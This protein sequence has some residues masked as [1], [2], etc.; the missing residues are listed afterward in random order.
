LQNFDSSEMCFGPLYECDAHH[1][2]AESYGRILHDSKV[3]H[4]VAIF[5]SLLQVDTRAFGQLA[6]WQYKTK[7][8][9]VLV[10]MRR[11]MA[12]PQNKKLPQPAEGT[13]FP[14]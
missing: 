9:D 4:P 8:V 1:V 12:S 7:I 5:P 14:Q 3:S 11:E 10:E 2:R 13:V 6:Q